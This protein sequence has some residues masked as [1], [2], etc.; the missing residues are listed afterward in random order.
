[1]NHINNE[2]FNVELFLDLN[3]NPEINDFNNEI[4]LFG[5]EEHVS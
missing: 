1:M 2:F 3:L 5:V 4:G